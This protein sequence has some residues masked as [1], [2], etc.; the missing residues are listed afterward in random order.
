MFSTPII[1]LIP[2]SWL[3]TVIPILRRGSDRE[4]IWTKRASQNLSD[5]G[6]GFR[7]EA[8]ELCLRV[9]QTPGVLGQ[10]V[11]GMIDKRD[12]STCETW[13]F[14][15]PH[16]LEIPTPVYIKIALP[17]KRRDLFVIS[18]HID[19]KGTLLKAI[20]EYQQKRL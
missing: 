11:H 16:P 9:L 17:M 12:D 2:E 13:A 7:F 10:E 18:F 19:T 14:L 8:Y 15:C 1:S 6:I 3:R 5:I 20:Q 4:I